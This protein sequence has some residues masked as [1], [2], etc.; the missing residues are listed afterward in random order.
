[1]GANKKAMGAKTEKSIAQE[2]RA[3][4]DR[5]GGLLPAGLR[6]ALPPYAAWEA[7]V[8]ERLLAHF[9]RHGYQR[10]EPP[11]IEFEST[12]LEGTGQALAPEMFRL[13]DPLSQRMMGLR[14]DMTLQV[15]RIAGTRYRDA[16][17]PLRFSYAG[18]VLRVR[19]SQLRPE[20]QFAQ[21]GVELIGAGEPAA[22]IEV[23][24]LAAGALRALGLADLSLDLTHPKLALGVAE[25]LGLDKAGAEAARLALDRKDA[26]A[27]K[28]AAGSAAEVMTGL[29][30]AAGPAALA[31]ERLGR[32]KLPEAAKH[33]IEEL[34]LVAKAIAAAEP[35]LNLT[36][37]PG[38][39]RGFE[40]HTGVSFSL[41][42]GRV[43]GE[44]GGGG[45]YRAGAG[46]QGE[47]ATG[48]T[49]Y[50]DTLMRALAPPAEKD[51]VYLPAG[52]DYAEA[53]ALRE[54]G[55]IAVQGL[56][57]SADIAAEARRLGCTH[58]WRRG[59]IEALG[60][61]DST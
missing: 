16:A 49:V 22:D 17:R 13:M 31:L 54:Q 34:E 21:A 10:V 32:L 51:S 59:K 47:P 40:Y 48:F 39:Y 38:E 1:M 60:K 36:I 56:T 23:A 44:L 55:W 37:D 2:D 11:L 24:L 6:D 53:C 18:P 5:S 9:A 30:R 58:V 12:L 41:F 14:T 43:R 8:I 7:A 61:A 26:A 28:M 20:R 42:A 35:R 19:G 45:R 15:A 29:L 27:L 52:T 3:D 57:A 50:V 33:M 46:D 25:G 4:E